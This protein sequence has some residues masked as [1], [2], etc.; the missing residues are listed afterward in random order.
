VN[1]FWETLLAVLGTLVCLGLF[2]GA[3]VFLTFAGRER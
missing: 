1:A 3:Y 2:L